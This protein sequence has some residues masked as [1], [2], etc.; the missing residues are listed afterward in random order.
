MTDQLQVFKSEEFGSL[1]ILTIEGNPYFPATECAS[2]LGYSNP[3]K[4]VRDHCRTDGCTNRSVIDRLGRT[5]EKR[6]INEGNLYRLIVRSKLP[7]A[8]RFENFVFD[9]IL[10]TIRKH[11]AYLTDA[12][13]EEAVRSQEFALE[14]VEKLRSEKNKTAALSDKVEELAPKARYCDA[15][16]RSDDAVQVSLIAR[17][18]GMTAMAFN[19][20]LHDLGIQ[21][22][23]GKTWVLYKRLTGQ[24]LT[25]SRTYHTPSGLA[26]IHTCWTQ[27]GRLF[28]YETLCETGIFPMMED[29]EDFEEEWA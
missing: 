18:Y 10:P 25:K 15:I 26:L 13:L 21:F 1:E 4:A 7:A 16:L 22:R 17:D 23:I 11:G 9:E 14:L 24:G 19:R 8:L 5:Q 29:F 6:Y 12:V 3:H 20:L 28:L 2:V 27:K